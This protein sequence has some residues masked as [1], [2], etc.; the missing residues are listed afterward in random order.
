MRQ[1]QIDKANTFARTMHERRTVRSFLPTP[2]H[3]DVLKACVNAA[4]SS[5]SGANQQPWHYVI[6]QDPALKATIRAAAEEEEQAFYGGRAPEAWLD[7]LKP[8]GTNADKPYLE[9]APAL[10]AVFAANYGIQP[11]TGENGDKRKH[12]YVQESVGISVGMLLTAL[13]LAGLASLTHTPSPMG[14]LS[15]VLN[16]PP[17]ERAYMLIATGYPDPS[18]VPPAITRRPFEESVTI[19]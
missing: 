4:L 19:R 3:L 2:I 9:V 5:P 10:I 7:A 8:I 15:S 13:H 12:Y 6:I 16:R 17:N 14:F 11:G 18:Y 1:E